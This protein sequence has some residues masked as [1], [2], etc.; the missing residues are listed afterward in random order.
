MAAAK[1]ILDVVKRVQ[2][3]R[4]HVIAYSSA[5]GRLENLYVTGCNASDIHLS[6]AWGRRCVYSL[7]K[8]DAIFPSVTAGE[9][10]VILT[11]ETWLWTAK[12]HAP[13]LVP[14]VEVLP[15]HPL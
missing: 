13:D 12:S 14:I 10:I 7:P 3:A 2:A 6:S 11:H 8:G 4:A 15:K 1:S 9:V 5:G